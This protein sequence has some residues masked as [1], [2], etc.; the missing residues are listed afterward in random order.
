LCHFGLSA[1]Q[2]DLAVKIKGKAYFVEG[3]ELGDHN[4]MHEP[5]GYCATIRKA[6]VSGQIQNQ[7]FKALSYELLP[8]E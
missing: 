6:K 8:M 7:K 4:K 3:V 2:C 1:P 5:G